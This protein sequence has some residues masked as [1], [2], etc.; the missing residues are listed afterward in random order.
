MINKPPVDEMINK[1]SDDGEP[2]SRYALCVIAAKRA[3]QIM[4][5]SYQREATGS[6]KELT[7]ACEEI[8][9]GKIKAVKD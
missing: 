1:L 7:Q 3:R 4:D 6:V 8:A 5:R 9:E 2:V